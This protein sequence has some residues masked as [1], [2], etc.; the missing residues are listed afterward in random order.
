ME[1]RWRTH[2]EM[3]EVFGRGG[4]VVGGTRTG[5]YLTA[6]E[7]AE[8][9]ALLEGIE[10]EEQEWVAAQRGPAMCRPAEPHATMVVAAGKGRRGEQEYWVQWD[11]GEEGWGPRPHTGEWGPGVR[12]GMAATREAWEAAKE[13]D[14]TKRKKRFDEEEELRVAEIG[15]LRMELAEVTTELD[16][17][18]VAWEERD[19][20]DE[21]ERLAREAAAAAAAEKD[22]K[23]GKKK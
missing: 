2:A 1:G 12:T 20:K 17:M 5:G 15:C 23:G 11:N 6:A 10:P 8:Y 21:E 19:K 18:K 3:G 16:D 13:L 7:R 9:T 14:V 4:R 22:K